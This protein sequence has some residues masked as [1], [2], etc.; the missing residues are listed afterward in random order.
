MRPAALLM[1]LVACGPP[2][3]SPADGE[4]GSGDGVATCDDPAVSPYAGTCVAD[5]FAAC[6]D[7]VGACTVTPGDQGVQDT[8][9]ENGASVVLDR[10]FG[11]V[12]ATL[13]GADGAVCATAEASG[14]V[15][16][17]DVET[18]WTRAADGAVLRICEAPTASQAVDC[19]DGSTF[20]LSTADAT[21]A[22]T[23]LVGGVPPCVDHVPPG[24][25]V[26]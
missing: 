22:A 26:R 5:F 2:G 1:L 7:P 25:F 23:C 10:T 14:P 3:A 11:G 21:A 15:A 8:T 12:L 19:P 6:F 16:G 24:D 4:D 9:W 13:T 17:C 18:I 20:E